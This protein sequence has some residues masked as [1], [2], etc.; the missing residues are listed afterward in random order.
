MLRKFTIYGA[1][2]SCHPDHDLFTLGI[3]GAS[4]MQALT[5]TGKS[6]RFAAGCHS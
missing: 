5:V 2:E 3:H 4:L 6:V 1:N